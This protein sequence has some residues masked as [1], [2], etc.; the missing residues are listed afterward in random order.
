MFLASE[1][2]NWRAE[3]VG[4]GILKKAETLLAEIARME[5]TVAKR[6]KTNHIQ[7]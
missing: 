4:L 1:G 7:G 5:Q 2:Y 6:L 3:S